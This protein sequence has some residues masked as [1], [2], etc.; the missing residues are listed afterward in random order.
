MET[1]T[2][3]QPPPIQPTQKR[4]YDTSHLPENDPILKQSGDD[5]AILDDHDDN[6]FRVYFQN[7]NGLKMTNDDDFFVSAVGFLSTFRA[8]VAC[9]A[10]TNVN[11]K[12]DEAYNR[13]LTQMRNCFQS[14][15]LVTSSSGLSSQTINQQGGTCTA[16]LGKWSARK[17]S[18]GHEAKGSFSWLRL[19]GRRGRFV[20]IITCY[21]VLQVSSIGLGAA[22]AY[23]QQETILWAAGVKIP[24]PKN[25]SMKAIPSF[26]TKCMVE[27][28]EIVLSLNANDTPTMVM[29]TIFCK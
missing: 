8:S 16:V 20:T 21:R 1:A 13:V 24:K 23:V 28:D 6:S 17:Q 3:K 14:A 11:W 15:K 4:S 25:Y 12:K 22:T 18:S 7:L 27:G 2:A 10:E 29:P 26:I 9:F 19:R 5:A